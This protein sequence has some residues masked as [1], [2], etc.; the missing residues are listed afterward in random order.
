M[1]KI[2]TKSHIFTTLLLVIIFSTSCLS[3]FAGP[4]ENEPPPPDQ[5]HKTPVAKPEPPAPTETKPTTIT[6]IEAD[7]LEETNVYLEFRDTDIRDIADVFSKISGRTII[8]GQG[9]KASVTLNIEGVPWKKAFDM[10]LKSQNL[11]YI[12]EKGFLIIRTFNQIAA[13]Q[14]QVPLET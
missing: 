4:I 10:I 13:E 12:E 9:V 1:K 8:V 6:K 11:G 7:E 2:K 14:K 5:T 3:S